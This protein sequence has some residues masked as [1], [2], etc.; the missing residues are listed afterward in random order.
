MKKYFESNNYIPAVK[1]L[2]PT[3]VQTGGVPAVVAAVLMTTGPP[4]SPY[5]IGQSHFL[6]LYCFTC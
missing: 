6:C 4:M 2:I 5:I 1:L 3:M